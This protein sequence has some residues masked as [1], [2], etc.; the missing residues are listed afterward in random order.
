MKNKLEEITGKEFTNEE[1]G[2]FTFGKIKGMIEVDAETTSND[3][4]N[5]FS[6]FQFTSTKSFE[7]SDW[8]ASDILVKLESNVDELLYKRTKTNFLMFSPIEGTVKKL[9]K[10]ARSLTLPVY[11][12]NFTS[13]SK[14]DS[15]ESNCQQ[16]LAEI[17]KV[18]PS[19]D[20]LVVIGYSYG[21]ASALE[22]AAM[23]RSR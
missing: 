18:L 22:L 16:V 21:C 2:K 12:V 19:G 23:M 15:I 14:T 10:L 11:G 13:E 7:V 3:V 17:Q 5:D 4:T 1:I 6:D 9:E 8:I 20:N